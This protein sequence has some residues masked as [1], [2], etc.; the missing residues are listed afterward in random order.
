MPHRVRVSQVRRNAG[1]ARVQLKEVADRACREGFPAPESPAKEV[2]AGI[3]WPYL[4]IRAK[5]L[6]AA[7]V[8]RMPVR[9]SAF[10]AP[11]PNLIAAEITELDESGFA[12]AKAMPV[13]EIEQEEIANVLCRDLREERLD[14][15]TGE[16]L[17]WLLRRRT[18][19]SPM[20]ARCAKALIPRLVL[21][22]KADI[23]TFPHF[24]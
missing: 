8:E 4:E 15:F 9:I 10:E 2:A 13:H 23:G 7:P 24:R 6:L 16:K 19:R 12:A 14:L 11:H 5:Q 3:G 20:P 18:S 1:R 22:T 17:D 21:R